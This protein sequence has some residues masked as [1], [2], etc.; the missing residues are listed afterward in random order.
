MYICIY[1]YMYIYI[2]TYILCGMVAVAKLGASYAGNAEY[3]TGDVM[4]LD[5][6]MDR[7]VHV[8]E[9]CSC[10]HMYFHVYVCLHA[11]TCRFLSDDWC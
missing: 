11:Y 1:V 9:P 4:M 7:R 5:V 2:Y 10:M 8:L 6:D 3:G